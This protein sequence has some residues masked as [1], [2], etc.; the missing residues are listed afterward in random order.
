VQNSSR[1]GASLKPDFE[2]ETGIRFQD[3]AASFHPGIA[4]LLELTS[5]RN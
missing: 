1:G 3:L 5:G 2:P 4:E